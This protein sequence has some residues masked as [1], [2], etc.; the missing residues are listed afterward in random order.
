MF[1]YEGFIAKA[2][3]YFARAADADESSQEEALWLL[4]GLEFLIR[5]P[6]ARVHPTL[7]AL[8]EGDSILHA[9]GIERARGIPKSIPVKTVIERL[10]KIDPNFGEDRGKA[11]A[12]L[13]EMRNE[14]L[15]SSRATVEIIDRTAWMPQFLDV[16]EAVCIHLEIEPGSLLDGEILAAAEAYRATADGQT[17]GVVR[18][19]SQEAKAFFAGLSVSE[20]QARAEALPPTTAA[21]RIKCPACDQEAAWLGLS[22]GR[23]TEPKYDDED[24]VIQYKL[25]RVVTTLVCSVCNLSLGS[26]AQVIAAGIDRL[27]ITEITEDR[28]EG[29]EDQMTYEDAMAFLGMGE[30]YGND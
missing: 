25:V 19:L 4:L 26:T 5:A 10:T 27:Y 24:Q 14:E 18:K 17:Q 2:A 9:A 30:E 29:W 6:L 28:Y 7:L 8:P 1:D 23:T 16:V 15:H 3:I 12:L 11:A 13:A 21:V 20:V 22:S